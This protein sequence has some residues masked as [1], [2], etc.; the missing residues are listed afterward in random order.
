M[1]D[2]L[3]IVTPVG[4][5][6][7]V[8]IS[9][10]G[11]LNKL[12]SPPTLEY[13][14]SVLVPIAEAKELIAELAEYYTEAASGKLTKK[15]AGWYYANEDGSKSEKAT[16][17]ILFNF[18]TATQFKDGNRKTINVFNSSGKA[19]SLKDENGH[20]L[21]IDNS[22][23]GCIQGLATYY[24][25]AGNDGL[26]LWLNAVQLVKFVEYDGNPGF[27]KIEGGDN[28]EG[29]KTDS[30]FA[31]NSNPNETEKSAVPDENKKT[32]AV[33]SL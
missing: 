19:I 25:N 27:K 23:R 12:K 31:N 1:N 21:K 16:E 13:R 5:L 15:T 18:K 26:S 9:G 7:Y 24:T 10:E 6:Q 20:H 4:R 8:T 32:Q 2:K 29:V 28:F 30:G 3:K 14:A 33:P 22:S 17:L 11:A